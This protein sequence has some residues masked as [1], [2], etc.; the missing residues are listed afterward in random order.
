MD[1]GIEQ[2]L[3]E[4]RPVVFDFDG[5]FNGNHVWVN[6]LR[7]EAVV[8]CRAD[9][10][11]LRR[12]AEAGVDTLILTTELVPVP[13]ARAPS[14]RSTASKPWRQAGCARGEEVAAREALEEIVFVG[15]DVDDVECLRAVG[16]PVVASDVWPDREHSRWV[17]E[18]R[19]G[20]GCVTVLCDVIWRAKGTA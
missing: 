17:L 9:G 6:E 20:E 18:R 16:L 13:S 12:L 7:G 3:R 4:V 10:F 14:S 1:P 19:G 2:A 8:C 11:S 15:N 5:V